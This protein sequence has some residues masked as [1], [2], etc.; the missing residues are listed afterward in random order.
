MG[1]ADADFLSE[2]IFILSMVKIMVKDGGENYGGENY[3]EGQ[4]KMDSDTDRRRKHV[5]IRPCKSISGGIF[6]VSPFQVESE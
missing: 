2:F 4:W 6:L 1:V 3:G 5:K